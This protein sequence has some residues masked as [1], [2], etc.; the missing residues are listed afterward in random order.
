VRTT[1]AGQRGAQG[2]SVSIALNLTG[3]VVS[4]EAFPLVRAF[5][6]H[7]P[8]GVHKHCGQRRGLNIAGECWVFETLSQLCVQV[9]RGADNRWQLAQRVEG[10]NTSYGCDFA[11][12]AWLVPTYRYLPV[13]RPVSGLEQWPT[14]TIDYKDLV[15]EVRSRS[16]PYL[17][18]LELTHGTLSF[19]MSAEDEDLLGIVLIILSIGFSCPLWCTI[20]RH[21]CRR[22]HPGIRRHRST[23]RNWKFRE[24]DPETVGM[25]YAVD[26]ADSQ[27]A[28][29]HGLQRAIDHA[30][31]VQDGMEDRQGQAAA[32][33]DA[34][35]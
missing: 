3:S 1:P 19:G 24:P 30:A 6:R 35:A 20:A 13:E 12:G 34:K 25:R 11:G 14:G 15:L 9:E 8:G 26:I 23:S 4:T 16:D 22:R 33:D 17:R 2:P 27:R 18:A 5:A 7:E 28:S 29:A 10:R 31:M 32:C 21:C